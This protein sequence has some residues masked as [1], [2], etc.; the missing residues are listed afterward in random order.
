[1]GTRVHSRTRVRLHQHKVEI[2]T[3]IAFNSKQIDRRLAL[4]RED[5]C[6]LWLSGLGRHQDEPELEDLDP[7]EEDAAQDIT[8]FG[9]IGLVGQEIDD[10]DLFEEDV[11]MEGT[12][13]V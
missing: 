12:V 8:E 6:S 2:G 1:M 7:E 10:N 4:T 3:A 11:L 5:S 9:H 13:G